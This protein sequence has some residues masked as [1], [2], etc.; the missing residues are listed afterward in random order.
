MRRCKPIIG[1]RCPVK[2]PRLPRCL[3]NFY[4]TKIARVVGV[5]ELKLCMMDGCDGS[6]WLRGA[7]LKVCVHSEQK[8]VTA[9][10]RDH[11]YS[12]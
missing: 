6:A 5:V 4:R 3:A 2:R 1:S 8:L 12:L 10:T 11:Y 7:I 9:F